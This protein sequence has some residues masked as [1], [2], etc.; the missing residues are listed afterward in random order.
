MP[1]ELKLKIVNIH[2][3]VGASVSGIGEGLTVVSRECAV[4]RLDVPLW[5]ASFDPTVWYTINKDVV[6]KYTHIH[7][8]KES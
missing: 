1:V 7:N 4:K 6:L 5:D 8:T 3:R 2:T